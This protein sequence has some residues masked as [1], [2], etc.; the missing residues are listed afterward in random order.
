MLSV[1]IKEVSFRLTILSVDMHNVAILIVI[2][3]SLI[4]LSVNLA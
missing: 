2:M 4:M 3:P 1:M